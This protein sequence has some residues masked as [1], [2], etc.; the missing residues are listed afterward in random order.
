MQIKVQPV[1]AE[2]VVHQHPT[3]ANLHF[4]IEDTG[5]LKIIDYDGT[6]FAAYAAGHWSAASIISDAKMH[7]TGDVA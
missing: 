4:V 1:D 7:V 6:I 5:V 2:P 3:G